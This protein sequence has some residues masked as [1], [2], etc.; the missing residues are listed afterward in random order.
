MHPSSCSTMSQRIHT[1][2]SYA[3][4]VLVLSMG[5]LCSPLKPNNQLSALSFE[6]LFNLDTHYTP[7]CMKGTSF[8]LQ[9]EN[10]DITLNNA[11]GKNYGL[12]KNK[13]LLYKEHTWVFYQL[14]LPI[15]RKPKIK[16]AIKESTYNCISHLKTALIMKHIKKNSVK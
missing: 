9:T 5:S 3:Q 12:C 4:T 11:M 1:D 7:E 6:S 13:Q 2:N 8:C 10:N 14:R 15:R 16:C